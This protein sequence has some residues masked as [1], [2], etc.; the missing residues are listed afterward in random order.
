MDVGKVWC[1]MTLCLER[2]TV[3]VGKVWCSMTLCLERHC[4]CW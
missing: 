4:G 3:D 2:G 1:S